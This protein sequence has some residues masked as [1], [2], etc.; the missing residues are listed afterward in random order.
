MKL[1][2]NIDDSKPLILV[3]RP[4]SKERKTTLETK[5]TNQTHQTHGTKPRFSGHPVSCPDD[6]K[7]TPTHHCMFETRFP[8]SPER[9]FTTKS[10]PR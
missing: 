9:S 3:S 7:R 4:E 5:L 8:P 2:F 10:A 1:R 6:S